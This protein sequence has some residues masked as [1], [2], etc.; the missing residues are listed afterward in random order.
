VWF[1]NAIVNHLS[2]SKPILTFG[3]WV[4]TFRKMQRLKSIGQFVVAILLI[5]VLT[6]CSAIGAPPNKALIARAIAIEVNETQQ[7]LTEQLR[8]NNSQPPTIEIN[9]I[10]IIEQT[11]FSIQNLPAYHI[12]G[13]YDLTLKLPTRQVTQQKNP[14]DIYLQRQSEGKTWKLARYELRE[15]GKVTWLTRLIPPS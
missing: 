11:P 15:G 1:L 10:N 13:T 6:A 3:I 7:I 2:A 5:G 8:R 4:Q 12:Q 9:H 14:F